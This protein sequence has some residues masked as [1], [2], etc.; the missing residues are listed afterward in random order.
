MFGRSLGR[1]WEQ[2]ERVLEGLS[3]EFEKSLMKEVREQFGRN[4]RR[5][6]GAIFDQFVRI[7]T[8]DY[9]DFEIGLGR[10]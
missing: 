8:G 3:V 9:Y 2:F 6:F 5:S 4:L 10:V 1:G 7:W